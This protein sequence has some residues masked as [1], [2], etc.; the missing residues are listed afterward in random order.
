MDYADITNKA[1]KLIE[2]AKGWDGFGGYLKLNAL[3]NE[4]GDASMN[5]VANER[6]VVQY[7]DGSAIREY[8][9][10]FKLVTSWSAER[11]PINAEAE[12]YLCGLVDW[13]N[14]QFPDN[15]PDWPG[16]TITD[17]HTQNNAPSLDFVH[18]QDE[19]AE[20]SINVIITYQE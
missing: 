1:D 14:D 19:L 11:D 16:A 13:V 20:Y 8:T 5:V 12:R 10:Q 3:V 6:V 7:I 9:A 4:E 2:W 15:L 17:I 18:E